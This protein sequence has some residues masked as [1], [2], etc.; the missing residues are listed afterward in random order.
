VRIGIAVVLCALV[1]PAGA[2]AKGPT[3]ATITGP[4]LAKPLKLGGPRGWN[5]NSPMAILV[6][7]GGFFQVA[8]GTEPARALAQSPTRN[9]G[10]KYQIVYFVPGPSNQGD[11]IRQ[12]LYPY[13][14]GACFG[15]AG[16]R[17]GGHGRCA[18][19]RRPASA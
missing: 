16:T 18:S 1:L 14:K 6:N 8:C 17:G 15:R 12:E 10:P 9:L 7:E 2:L 5:T 4:G 3:T 11:R 13:A 19:A